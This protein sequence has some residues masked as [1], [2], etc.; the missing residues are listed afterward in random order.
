M[1]VVC[2][3]G[4]RQ[5]FSSMFFLLFRFEQQRSK[6]YCLTWRRMLGTILQYPLSGLFLIFEHGSYYPSGRGNYKN[7]SFCSLMMTF[8]VGNYYLKKTGCKVSATPTE[9]YEKIAFDY[10]AG[11]DGRGC[12]GSE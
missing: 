9:H 2:R 8:V 5:Y 11:L 7:L 6:F 12:R 10:P 1:T 4:M 3:T